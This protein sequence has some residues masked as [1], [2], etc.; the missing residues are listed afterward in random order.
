MGVGPG[1][2]R[3]AGE[4]LPR[5]RA[6]LAAATAL[7]AA[8]ALGVTRV[9]ADET[10][11]PPATS[12][13]TGGAEDP[14]RASLPV[15]P[16]AVA[17]LVSDY[18]QAVLRE[19]VVDVAGRPASCFCA[20]SIS[21]S[22]DG[23]SSAVA[24]P[25][26]TAAVADPAAEGPELARSGW[27]GDATAL[28]VTGGGSA[29]ASATSGST[30]AVIALRTPSGVAGATG[31]AG[32]MQA[33]ATAPAPQ[34]ATVRVHQLTQALRDLVEGLGR[35]LAEATGAQT[36]AQVTDLLAGL[37]R[38]G[39]R[40]DAEVAAWDGSP[41]GA[42]DGTVRCEPPQPGQQAPSCALAIAVTAAGGATALVQFPP[43][44][45]GPA[46]S[47]DGRPGR[48]GMATAVSVAVSGTAVSTARTG[49]E[50]ARPPHGAP[51]ELGAL[52]T[53][54][55]VAGSSASTSSSSA[56]SGRSGGS[57]A[58]A[59]TVRGASS[60]R[61]SSGDTG[62]AVSSV[63]GGAPA[64]STA[65]STGLPGT[66]GA[67]T[68]QATS[69]DSGDALTLAA[70]STGADGTSASGSTGD[71][72]AAAADGPAGRDWSTDPAGTPA[73]AV[74]GAGGS[75]VA[76]SRTG[77]TGP[78][79]SLVIS[80]GSAAATAA[81]GDTGDS[82]ATA[83]GGSGGDTHV[84][85]SGAGTARSGD[86]GAAQVDGASGGTGTSVAVLV[87]PYDGDGASRTGR[88]GTVTSTARGG[89]AGCASSGIDPQRACTPPAPSP[90]PGAAE[91]PVAADSAGPWPSNA[92]WPTADVG[93]TTEARAP[94]A[95]GR[96]SWPGGRLG[97][98]A[99]AGS[100]RAKAGPVARVDAR[101]ADSAPVEC[102][103]TA[104]SRRCRS[105]DTPS[106]RASSSTR[107]ERSGRP[108]VA[109]PADRAGA[110]SATARVSDLGGTAGGPLELQ[111]AAAGTRAAPAA[112][113]D[114]D[115]GVGVVG[116]LFNAAVPLL[117]LLALVAMVAASRRKR[118][119]R[120][121]PYVP[122]HRRKKDLPRSRPVAPRFR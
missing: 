106:V 27:S 97:G 96:S 21:V 36:H 29:S 122:R 7:L 14:A 71:A 115:R 82:T 110:A 58:V 78:S 67:G 37:P 30:G 3:G 64:A 43:A 42:A 90:S 38:G 72:T 17:A 119:P 108:E 104:G 87:T 25:G 33:A 88:S 26:R 84:V 45:S 9:A 51:P 85:G 24:V 10:P 55:P 62:S 47:A 98:S 100:A 99:T 4:S 121:P 49:D 31:D 68:A 13:A 94:A 116:L 95:A 105:A 93:G 113:A 57:L 46:L 35:Q 6:A 15:A 74:G 81:S 76:T 44:G 19:A 20:I 73:L 86:G 65:A 66:G 12:G 23:P 91:E 60:S 89:S 102:R 28:S 117:A 56:A 34:S 48:P 92:W 83:T 80:G 101:S 50:G 107:P 39:S 1:A 41:E 54:V 77:P 32:G 16:G 22:L 69:G 5:G 8:L 103:A 111:P 18:V 52:T 53:G 11:P 120:T 79:L 61:A 40:V 2:R 59:L 109:A 118:S 112:A 114:Q 70:G 63:L 75:A